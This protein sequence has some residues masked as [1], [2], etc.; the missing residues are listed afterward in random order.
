M[1]VPI[2]FPSSGMCSVPGGSQGQ[3]AQPGFLSLCPA[4]QPPSR[5]VISGSYSWPT[6]LTYFYGA[7][8]WNKKTK[9]KVLGRGPQEKEVLSGWRMAGQTPPHL[10]GLCRGVCVHCPCLQL[11]PSVSLE[12]GLEETSMRPGNKWHIRSDPKSSCLLTNHQ[13]WGKLLT[14]SEPRSP[15]NS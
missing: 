4:P 2:L 6:Y 1:W 15:F 8:F 5:D 11:G 10:T 14:F 3:G 12:R 7:F 13:I 9:K